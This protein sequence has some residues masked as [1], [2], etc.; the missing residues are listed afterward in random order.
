MHPIIVWVL[1]SLG[2]Q[3]YTIQT[4]RTHGE[5][6]Q[7]QYNYTAHVYPKKDYQRQPILVCRQQVS[8]RP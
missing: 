4:F 3:P 6:V 8:L 1:I 7:A 2:A 5:C